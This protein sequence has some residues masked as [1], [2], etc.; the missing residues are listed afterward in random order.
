MDSADG[1]D[2]VSP[3]W[4]TDQHYCETIQGFYRAQRSKW[5]GLYNV[6]EWTTGW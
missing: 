1:V 6:R 5:Q 4:S 3:K 2:F